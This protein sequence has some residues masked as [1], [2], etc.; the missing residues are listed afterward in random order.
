M[1]SAWKVPFHRLH[2]IPIVFGLGG[3]AGKAE[4]I[5]R[6]SGFAD[7]NICVVAALSQALPRPGRRTPRFQLAPCEFANTSPKHVRLPRRPTQAARKCRIQGRRVRQGRR[8]VLAGYP[9]DPGQ[10]PA[11]HEPCKC[12]PQAGP[13]A[14]G[15]G[16]LPAQHKAVPGK[17]EGLLLFGFVVTAENV[18]APGRLKPCTADQLARPIRAAPF[19]R[20]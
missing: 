14:G 11:L 20:S 10:P 18:R 3:A 4:V 12:P 13:V 19:A 9:A 6:A 5:L 7:T 17:H 1:V 2:L 15:H 16:R 8:P